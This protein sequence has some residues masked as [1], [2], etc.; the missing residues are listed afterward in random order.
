MNLAWILPHW[1]ANLAW[2]L[3]RWSAILPQPLQLPL[4]RPSARPPQR[5]REPSWCQSS[6]NS[7]KEL[8]Y[9][10]H[11]PNLTLKLTGLLL[12]DIDGVVRD[13]GGSYRRAIQET[14][15]HFCT[16]R[17]EIES[18]DALKAEGCW[19]NDWDASLEILRRHHN[20]HKPDWPLPSRSELVNVFSSFYFGGDPDG[21]PH[22]WKGFIC[23]EP[24]LV[25]KAFFEGLNQQGWGWGFVSGAEPPS[26]RFV[27]EQRLGLDTPPLIAM[28][29]A[30]DKPDP[31]GLIQLTD[32]LLSAG[33]KQ[34]HNSDQHNRSDHHNNHANQTVA[35]LGDTV[36]DVMTVMAA[37]HRRPDLNWLSLAVAPPHLW[38]R[39]DAR[40]TYEA[41]LRQAGADMILSSTTSLLNSLEELSPNR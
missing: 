13:V 19:N 30:P 15:A 21:D 3:P 41:R 5:L 32:Q 16:E 31:T 18:I 22:Q 40:T 26:A 8:T 20:Q 6:I 9:Q 10:P 38:D 14:V 1:L 34:H 2:I 12:F 35:Y 37:R 28:G 7:N 11:N 17:P 4:S 33:S 39:G 36:A 29:D 25:D 24:L 27:L 23:D